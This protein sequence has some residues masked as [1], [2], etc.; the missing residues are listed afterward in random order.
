MRTTGLLLT[1][2]LC[3]ATSSFLGGCTYDQAP[4]EPM[5]PTVSYA[6]EIKPII[7]TNC[8]SCHSS[9]A[10]DPDRP[11]YAFFD[12]FAELKRYALKPSTTN[13]AYTTL[14]ARLRFIEFPGM[15]FQKDPLPEAEILLVEAWIEAG[16]P[17]N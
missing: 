12:D 2:L 10:T 15:P 5:L 9:T 8:Y 16:A 4:E 17:N 1:S 7:E 13:A 6:T 14:Q 11:G 3:L